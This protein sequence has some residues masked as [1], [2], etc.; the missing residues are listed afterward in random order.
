METHSLFSRAPIA[1]LRVLYIIALSLIACLAIAGQWLIQRTLVAVEQDARIV[2]VAGRQ[3]MLSQRISRTLLELYSIEESHLASSVTS[4]KLHTLRE[5]LELWID[6]QKQLRGRSADNPSEILETHQVEDSFASIENDF[7]LIRSAGQSRLEATPEAVSIQEIIQASD[8]FLIGME[9]IVGLYETEARDRVSRLESMERAL[10]L[11]TLGVLLFEGLFIFTPAIR[12]LVRSFDRLERTHSE[13]VAAKESADLANKA[14][15]DFLARVSHELRTP[16][17]AILGT[18]G[19]IRKSTL[20]DADVRR[21]RMAS[22]ATRHLN[23]LVSDLLDISTLESRKAI[24]VRKKKVKSSRFIQVVSGLLVPAAEQKGLA[25][26]SHTEEPFPDWIVLDP[27]RTQQI[28]FNLLQNAIRYTDRGFVKLEL[29]FEPHD[30]GEGVQRDR[31][32]G[33]IK[34]RVSD[35]G[36][37]ISLEHQRRIFDAFEIIEHPSARSESIRSTEELG[38]RLGLGLSVVDSLVKAMDGTIHLESELGIGT[39]ICVSLPA[40]A[41]RGEAIAPRKQKR[42]GSARPRRR[43]LDRKELRPMAFVVDDCRANRILMR[44]YLQRLGYQTRVFATGAALMQ[45]LQSDTPRW[46]ILDWELP[47]ISGLAL[48]TALNRIGKKIDTVVITADTLAAPSVLEHSYAVSACFFKPIE[49]TDFQMRFSKLSDARADERSFEHRQ[50]GSMPP[51]ESWLELEKRLQ[52]LVLEQ[53]LADCREL[54]KSIGA[55]RF[56][57]IRMIAHR[58][59]GSAGNARLQHLASIMVSLEQAAI[60]E[61]APLCT[62]LIDKFESN[63]PA[64][65]SKHS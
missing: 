26:Q 46:L 63:L 21:M 43:L 19:L 56:D 22:Q 38:T 58:L 11:I 33:N 27:I 49:F 60:D 8:R 53:G 16:L 59:Q 50:L 41:M 44:S 13:L 14:K 29:A 32:K 39:S 24:H 48:L 57:C 65:D 31:L 3:R 17:H 6:S 36:I 34:I 12:S 51:G 28:I 20:S 52:H 64:S 2:N 45:A 40:I 54:R 10:L 18:L 7:E 25:F 42:I 47:D 5:D 35:S 9:Q 62:R 61:D 30:R 23:Q 4:I 1:R 37:G 15:S 55:N